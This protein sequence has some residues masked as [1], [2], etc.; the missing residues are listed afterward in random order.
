[1]LSQ[2]QMAD[3]TDIVAIM[4]RV[5]PS[6][7]RLAALQAAWWATILLVR[8]RHDVAALV[9]Q[10]AVV[11]TWALTSAPWRAALLQ[12]VISIG[13]GL[14]SDGVMMATDAIAFSPNLTA[15]MGVPLF[16]IG[17]W[18]GFGVVLTH[19]PRALGK[20]TWL[21]A[22]LGAVG[23][24]LAYRGG[25]ISEAISFPQGNTSLVIVALVWMVAMPILARATN[26][27]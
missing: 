10:A 14:A 6:L 27:P 25:A 2:R 11:A 9:P 12:V 7:L 19:L 26:E 15:L 17:L 18:A 23:G 16:M 21:W 22:L 1:M 20:R 8:A 5:W 24:P 3:A 13:V 4:K